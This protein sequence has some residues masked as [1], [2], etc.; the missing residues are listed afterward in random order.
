MGCFSVEAT[1]LF[2]RPLCWLQR[3]HALSRGHLPQ[4]LRLC[5]AAAEGPCG[6]AAAL[7]RSRRPACG[8]VS[9][10][11]AY[12]VGHGGCVDSMMW[13]APGA[14]L[15]GKQL[16]RAP[17]WPPLARA[18]NP[19]KCRVCHQVKATAA[20]ANVGR[21]RYLLAPSACRSIRRPCRFSFVIAVT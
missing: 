5:V 14:E 15:S 19:I 17:A 21:N 18:F 1:R 20:R 8:Q 2:W 7:G 10:L 3:N 13:C 12:Q 16:T 4:G 9:W 6:P 11:S